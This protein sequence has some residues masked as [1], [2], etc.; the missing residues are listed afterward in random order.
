MVLAQAK[1]S[2]IELH[3]LIDEL[4]QADTLG[5]LR[6][7]QG[8]VR[9]AYAAIQADTRERAGPWIAAACAHMRRFGRVRVQLF[10]E[11]LAAEKKKSAVCR[12][13]R[14]IARQPGN[15]MVRGHGTR[16]PEETTT[17]PTQLRL[18]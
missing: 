16:K 9:K 7:A 11:L 17:V 12:T 18:V 1:F 3:A 5:H 13:D 14:E 8:L 10:E 4:F 2:H 6:R 15:P